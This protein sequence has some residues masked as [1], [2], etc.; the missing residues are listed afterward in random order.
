M[1]NIRYMKDSRKFWQTRQKARK[2]LDTR[3]ANMPL[4]EKIAILEKLQADTAFLKSGRTVSSK[5]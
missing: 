2:N 4:S 1:N 5:S 3:R